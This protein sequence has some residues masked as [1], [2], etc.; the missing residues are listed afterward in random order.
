MKKK[1]LTL[2]LLPIFVMNVFGGNMAVLADELD[3]GEPTTQQTTVDETQAPTEAP[4][5]SNN[6]KADDDKPDETPP[7][8]TPS[9][10][11]TTPEETPSS[12]DEETPTTDGETPTTDGG[13]TDG[14]TPT[15]DG[16]TPTTDGDT[17]DG[18]PTDTENPEVTETPD[19]QV[20]SAP[21]MLAKASGDAICG[22][23]AYIILYEDGSV[24]VQKGK[25]EESEN[26]VAQYLLGTDDNPIYTNGYHSQAKTF[27]INNRLVGRT[28]LYRFFD[29]WTNLTSADVSNIDT[30][31]V[32]NASGCFSGC[33][34]LTSLDLS[35]WDTSSITDMSSLVSG[36]SSLKT[37]N[38]DNFDLSSANEGGSWLSGCFGGCSALTS[39]SAKNWD[40][41][42]A[43]MEHLWGR[44]WS[45]HGSNI[46]VDVS[47]WDLSTVTSLQGA[48]ADASINSITGYSSWNTSNVTNMFQAFYGTPLTTIDLSGWNFSKVTDSA[49]MFNSSV[50][51][52]TLPSGYVYKGNYGGENS[53][54]SEAMWTNGSD[55]YRTSD[56]IH[57]FP[58]AGTYEVC[59]A[60]VGVDAYIICYKD[61]TLVMQKG[62]TPDTDT[63]GQVDYIKLWEDGTRFTKYNFGN[64]GV[65]K[66]VI[67]DYIIGATSFKFKNGWGDTESAFQ[68]IPNL[69]E[70]VDFYKFDTSKISDFSWLFN[71]SVYS[72]G[73]FAN[74]KTIDFSQKVCLQA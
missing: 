38:M 61:G 57:N 66:L 20:A 7:E 14:E 55:V 73:N 43:K 50:T 33:S 56:L 48:F 70:I 69:E 47:G 45:M 63:Y 30:S 28:S 1:L 31:A 74:L 19:G 22:E 23:D 17:T 32:T 39:V 53:N 18:E 34:S 11:D 68:G 60:T 3:S 49:M 35:S 44:Y 29:S 4:P 64:D 51:K 46:P 6:D 59:S 41:L 15:T 62:N 27:T 9:T 26:I 16:E 5:S 13:T 58:G 2:A 71:S 65:K 24:V 72:S 40:N 8:E 52:I 37:L 10:G 25:D 42:P 54:L 36:C 67:K 21:A 12:G